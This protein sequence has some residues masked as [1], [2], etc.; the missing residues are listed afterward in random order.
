MTYVGHQLS[1]I[2]SKSFKFS[3]EI[4]PKN[5]KLHSIKQA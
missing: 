4:Y 2:F 1:I 3:S 5:L